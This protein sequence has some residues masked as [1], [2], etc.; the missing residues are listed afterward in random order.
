M[1]FTY[2][3]D[4]AS[5]IEPPKLTNPD[6]EWEKA[7]AAEEIAD[8]QLKRMFLLFG[9]HGISPGDWRGLCYALAEA[10]VPGFQ[11]AKGRAGRPRKWS[12]LDRARLVIE[13]QQT[14]LGATEATRLLA[15]QEP[16]RSMLPKTKTAARTLHNEYTRA[17][18][19]WV[20]IIK[21]IGDACLSPKDINVQT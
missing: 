14:E 16:W 2:K 13:V 7:D 10:H 15:Q 3:G 11:V 1:G 17:D 21:A 6:S 12:D 8:Q 9:A 4:L 5:P 20:E 19:R 18:P